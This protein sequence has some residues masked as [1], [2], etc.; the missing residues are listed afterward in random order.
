M[1]R[2]V[3]KVAV[4]TGATSGIGEETARRFAEEGAKVVLSG[5]NSGKGEALAEALGP[6]AAFVRADVTVEA[7]VA[8]LITAAVDKFGRLDCLFN[9]AGEAIG[10]SGVADVT[11]QEIDANF[12]TLIYSVI[13]GAKYA[14]RQF[15][16]Q[17][18]GGVVLNNASIAAE[19]TG[20]GS[21]LYSAAKAA[22]VRL[23][24]CHAMETA[25]EAIRFNS[26][27][28]GAIMTPIFARAMGFG[29]EREAERTA[30]LEQA[31]A[32]AV[33]IARAGRP[34]DIAALAVFLASD[35]ASYITAQDIA[36]DGGM[37]AGRTAGQ[38][39]QMFQSL[40]ELIAQA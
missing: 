16:A 12:R 40:A 20:Y 29:G 38:S 6:A 37:T 31:F 22:V 24:H 36:A 7:D 21:T 34:G 32:T 27:S 4:I 23:T 3:D 18:G 11:E 39:A 13:F 19:R 30:V 14:V 9:N 17:G 10:A 8:D 2:L 26:I 5:R 15:R 35:E 33:P 1:G 25:G 28:P